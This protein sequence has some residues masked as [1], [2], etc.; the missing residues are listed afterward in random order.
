MGS[1][2]VVGAQWGDE[3]KGKIVDCLTAQADWVVRFHGGNNAGHTLVVNGV[4]TKLSLLPSGVLREGAIC[5]LAAGV[6]FN[7]EVLLEEIDALD[8]RGIKL[9]PERLMI[10]RDAHLVLD[11]H[12][13]LDQEREKSRGVNKIG[14]TGRG[15]GPAYEDR[16]GRCGIRAAHLLD[17]DLLKQEIKEQVKQKN[18]LIELFSGGS[19]KEQLSCDKVYEKIAAYAERLAPYVSNVSLKL[20]KALQFGKKVIFE[21]AQG[22]LLDQCFGTIP[23]VTSSHTLAGSV[24]TGCGIG[25]KR[26]GH[27]LG[28]AKAYSTRVGEGPFPTELNNK[29]GEEIRSKGHEFGTVTGR[30]RRCGWLDLTLLKRAIRLNG[31]D[32]LAITKLDV[33]NGLSHISVATEYE[34]KGQ[35]LEDVPSL[36]SHFA[37]VQPLY[38]DFEGWG[39]LPEE[40]DSHNKLPESLNRFITFIEEYCQVP[41]SLLGL[42]AERKSLVV[43]EAGK[44]LRGYL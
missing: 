23:Y 12:I 35:K 3:G 42:G 43:T 31:I 24:A 26:I 10:D 18:L 19:F 39:E 1:I 14:T 7:P 29:I 44:E 37:H 4:K 5:A 20:D 28:V 17:L 11:Y 16:A 15:I 40:F 34:L 38:R 41:V 13:L 33:L 22:T 36:A 27:V 25:P 30:P 32:S 6:V 8:S 21:G 9:T 2:V